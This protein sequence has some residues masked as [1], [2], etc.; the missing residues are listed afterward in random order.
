LQR[1]DFW[2]NGA[3]L[4]IAEGLQWHVWVTLVYKRD[5]LFLNSFMWMQGVTA[6]CVVL[7]GCY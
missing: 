5:A 2:L 4:P 3:D 7:S 6:V 1:L